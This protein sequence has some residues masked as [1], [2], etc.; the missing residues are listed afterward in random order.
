MPTLDPDIYGA[1]KVDYAESLG[2]RVLG[3]RPPTLDINSETDGRAV[4][5][6]NHGTQGGGNGDQGEPSA[7]GRGGSPSL[8]GKTGKP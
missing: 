5:E 4:S 8:D 1:D 7:I 2:S 6:G 3:V